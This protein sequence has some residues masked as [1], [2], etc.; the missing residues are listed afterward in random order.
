MLNYVNHSM[1]IGLIIGSRISTVLETVLRFGCGVAMIGVAIQVVSHVAKSYRCLANAGRHQV[2]ESL[3]DLKPNSTAYER[4]TYTA[5]VTVQWHVEILS[6]L[7]MLGIFTVA[8]ELAVGD[9]TE[10]LIQSLS[11]GIGFGLK[12]IMQDAVYGAMAIMQGYGAKN[13]IMSVKANNKEE[14]KILD[15]V[16]TSSSESLEK[17][18]E[19]KSRKRSKA[20]GLVCTGYRVY[21]AHLTHVVLR[22][23]Y[24]GIEPD[25][26]DITYVVKRWTSFYND[27]RFQE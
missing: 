7:V 23:C 22:P 17:S 16:I 6:A 19:K 15:S 9:F 21:Q 12:E 8:C 26:A 13:K 2:L 5:Q 4:K 3:K 11:V 20:G 25:D 27:L 24:F 10:S 14:T 1:S 18:P